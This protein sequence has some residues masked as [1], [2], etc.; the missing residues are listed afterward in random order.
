[1]SE[2]SSLAYLEFPMNSWVE[3]AA[4]C[5]LVNILGEKNIVIKDQSVQVPL[6]SLV[7]FE[8][9]YFA[10][11]SKQYKRLSSLTKILSYREI[12]LKHRQEH[13]EQFDF[14]SLEQLKTHLTNLKKYGTS[15]S[16]KKVY[17]L[18]DSD[19]DIL[20]LIDKVSEASKGISKVKQTHF[21]ERKGE[22]IEQVQALYVILERVF[23]YY[24]DHEVQRYLAAKI[25]IYSVINNGYNNVSFLNRQESSGDFFMK[26][27]EYFVE[28]VFAYLDTDHQK[29]NHCCSNCDRPIKSSKGVSY[30]FINQ[31]G[32]DVNK[33]RS[34]AWNFTNDLMMCPVCQLLYTCLPAGFTYVY[35][36][37][38]FVNDNHSAK[39]MI[40][41]NRGIL[42]DVL[43][44][45]K[46]NVKTTNT[47]GALIRSF[48]N[49][50]AMQSTRELGDIQIVRY[51]NEHYHFS[52]L[53]KKILKTIKATNKQLESLYNAFFVKG[54]D[55]Y[56]VYEETISCLLN[57]TNLFMLLF[58]VLREKAAGEKVR[59]TDNQ[60]IDLIRI[61]QLFLKELFNMEPIKQEQLRKIQRDGY[62]FKKGYENKKKAD[63]IGWRMLNALRTNDKNSFMDY[64]LNSYMYLNKQV[65]DYFLKVFANDEHFKTVGY[66][67]VS[68][69]IGEN[70]KK[71]EG[72]NT[73]E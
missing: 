56:S 47:Y 43:T 63:S 58:T 21:A 29:D 37:G 14:K 11:F 48:Q 15:P 19:I 25:Q 73:D 8:E 50:N 18:V 42:L 3:N 46:Q 72:G 70:K 20:A 65:P 34:N 57:N 28:P 71:T 6:S 62:F 53:S 22:I 69:I 40:T 60:M 68:G 49:Q 13:F 12:W 36:Q 26:Y 16:Y 66:S 4:I 9:Q 32:F 30:S 52:L 24:Q 45:N 1:M 44:L 27:H 33:K 67:F 39:N 35:N 38:L 59:I 17:P 7:N 61:N 2:D 5:G 54:K 10:Y 55:T 51:E 64:L 31:L 23:A 41:I